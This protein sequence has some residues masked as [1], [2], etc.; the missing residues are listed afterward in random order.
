MLLAGVGV[1]LNECIPA[2]CP[3]V[4]VCVCLCVCVCVCVC[5]SVCVFVCVRVCMCAMGG[6]V[7]GAR[8]CAC[9]WACVCVCVWMGVARGCERVHKFV[10]AC[11]PAGCEEFLSLALPVDRV[12]GF[13][14]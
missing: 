7:G 8:V 12:K 9:G 1:P 13:R 3:C 4:C 10:R 11:L 6:W 2:P 14:D 5:V